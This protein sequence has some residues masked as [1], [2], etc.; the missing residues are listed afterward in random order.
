VN[1]TS[2]KYIDLT[3]LKENTFGESSIIIEIMHMFLKDIDGFINILNNEIYNQNWPK[4]FQETH[5]IKPNIS[6]FGIM[7]LKDS[8]IKLEN[9]FRK[10]EELQEVQELSKFIIACLK[11][12]KKEIRNELK[13]LPDE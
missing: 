2:Y 13:S 10:E 6:M 8:I 3:D 12:V 5:K 1:N 4:L 7:I 9:C 11:E